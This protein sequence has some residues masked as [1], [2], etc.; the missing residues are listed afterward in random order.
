MALEELPEDRQITRAVL[1]GSGIETNYDLRTAMSRTEEGIDNYYSPFDVLISAVS[2]PKLVTTPD[3]G[4]MAAG[5]VGFTASDDLTD[6]EQKAY[7]SKLIQHKYEMGM[8][9][10]Y[11][12][13][14]SLWLDQP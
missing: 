10:Q 4:M 12:L 6:A 14:G 8:M 3:S 7:D 1:L 13:G 11:N 2:F 5:A 9:Q